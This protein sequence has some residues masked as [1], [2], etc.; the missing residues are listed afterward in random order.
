MDDLRSK[1]KDYLNSI[2]LIS[3]QYLGYLERNEYPLNE[4]NKLSFDELCE[5]IIQNVECA[6]SNKDA[7]KID[8]VKRLLDEI[9]RRLDAEIVSLRSAS[10]GNVKTKSNY[11]SGF[12]K[13]KNF[14][15]EH[16][17]PSVHISSYRRGRVL[18]DGMDSIIVK[19]GDTDEGFI[20]LVIESCIFFDSALVEER[21][22]DLEMEMKAGESV[23][24][25][26]TNT[27]NYCSGKK[28]KR[29]EEGV[30]FLFPSS[31][32]VTIKIDKDGNRKVRD[33]IKKYTGH[34][35]MKDQRYRTMTNYK[36][37]HIWGNAFNPVYF[38]SFWNI[39]LVPYFANDLLDG[40]PQEGSLS[41]KLL[42]TIKKICL[43]KYNLQ[44]L[45][46]GNDYID[47]QQ[48]QSGI[49][50]NDIQKGEYQLQVLG[51]S[52]N[53]KIIS[54]IEVEEEPFSI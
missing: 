12:R 2:G 8:Y 44:K 50:A 24:R 6:K 13:F 51:K 11:R 4:G 16:Y 46:N 41:S 28:P 20:K 30:K 22:H 47:I 38:T 10:A 17:L 7:K 19:C 32:S 39:V 1:F 21:W 9:S 33:L 40:K 43:E 48:I 26:S 3:T 52:N 54:D 45:L 27:D 37:S 5:V 23:A 36:I 49:D 31:Q 25:L 34:R 53:E 35:I 42:C 18:Y 14:I 15:V 29:G